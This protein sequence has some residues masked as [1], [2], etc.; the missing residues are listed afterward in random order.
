MKW[1]VQDGEARIERYSVPGG[2]LVRNTVMFD[3]LMKRDAIDPGIKQPLSGA[4]GMAFYP[5]PEHKWEIAKPDPEIK[6]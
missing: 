4:L 3:V 5:D 2:W 6:K 1:E